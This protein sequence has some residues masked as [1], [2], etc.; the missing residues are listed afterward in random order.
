MKSQ[1]VSQQSFHPVAA[2]SDTQL[3]QFLSEL[4]DELN[5]RHTLNLES[6]IRA[7]QQWRRKPGQERWEMVDLQLSE[8]KHQEVLDK[9]S[10]LNLVKEIKPES[11]HFEYALVLGA[12]V[13]RMERRLMHLARLWQEGIRFNQL[14]FLVGQRKL[15]EGVDKVDHLI[16]KSSNQTLLPSALKTE[17]DGSKLVYQAL[18]IPEAMRE[19]PV[20]FVDSPDVWTGEEWRRANT[21]DTIEYWL[22]QSPVSGTTLV[23]SDQPHALYQLEVVR[24]ALG[25]R[26]VPEVAAKEA[27]TDTRIILYLDALALWLH[28]LKQSID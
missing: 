13:P 17:T 7:T 24:Q 8:E 15:T 18:E 2:A 28:N 26:F 5:I 4:L 14:I 1:Q 22:K 27:D 11:R 19:R 6:I 9:L 16:S 12:T 10:K 20:L 25:N 3:I 21:R 23:L